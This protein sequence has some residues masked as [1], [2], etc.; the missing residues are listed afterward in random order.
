MLFALNL[1]NLNTKKEI[2]MMTIE[3][4]LRTLNITLPEPPEPAAN[5]LTTKWVGNLIYTSGQDARKN[6]DLMYLGKLGKNLSVEEG[7][8][9]AQQTILN[10][11]G[12]LK[13]ELGSLDRIKQFIKLTGYV[14]STD[15]F[16]EQPQVINGASDLLVKIFGKR[17]QHVRS[18]ISTN[19]LPF[20]IS[21]EIELI[22]E[23]KKDL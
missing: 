17:G 1:T 7:H 14:N 19:S 13:A 16:I 12:T 2:Y 20:G 3:K 22:A 15:D 23:I 5:Y 21:V 18:A 9:S 6:G 8:E 4:R 10:C 11:L